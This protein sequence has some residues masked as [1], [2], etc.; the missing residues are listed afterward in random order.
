MPVSENWW[1]TITEPLD[2]RV[3][4]YRNLKDADLRK[5]RN[6]FM[7]EGE[8]VVRKALR[9]HLSGKIRMESVL[10]NQA[11]L[12]AMEDALKPAALGGLPILLGSQEL[13]DSIAGFHVHRGCLSV[14]KCPN[15]KSL[16]ETIPDHEKPSV[17]VGCESI[18][19]VD[20]LGVIFRNV[21]AFAA[22]AVILDQRSCDPLYRRT[23]RVSIGHSLTV[24]YAR[25]SP[26]PGE[27]MRLK[28]RG[29][30]LVALALRENA[31]PLHEYHWPSRVLLLLGT[32]GT[33]LHQRTLEMCDDCLVIPMAND[34]DSLNVGTASGVALHTARFQRFQDFSHTR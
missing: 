30:H 16:E 23:L 8:L 19:N 2:T 28:E 12:N 25:I 27:L 29:Y 33:G 26:W 14:G 3:D 13:L 22:D 1:Q 5:R 10:V 15:E 17:I 11:R 18:C 32:E 21:A 4:L 31:V 6:R 20:N 24:P 34:V 9:L 7:A